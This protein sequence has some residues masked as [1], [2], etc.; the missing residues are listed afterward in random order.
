MK[1]NKCSRDWSVRKQRFGVIIF[2]TFAAFVLPR[3]SM[4]V[5]PQGQT[6]LIKGV[7]T[8]TRGLPLPGVTVRMEGTN[9]GVASDKDGKFALRVNGREGHIVVSFVGYKPQKLHFSGDRHFTI[10][11]VES[12][13][14]LDEV[15]V[16]AYGEQSKREV[17]GSV[18]SVKAGELRDNSLSNIASMLQGQLA[19]VVIQTTSGQP[20]AEAKVTVRGNASLAIET[21]RLGSD[22]LWVVDGVPLY[23][24]QEYYSGISPLSLIPTSDIER[25]DVLKDA[26]SCALYGSRAANGVV[27]VTTKSG[28]YNEKFTVSVNVTQS[29]SFRSLL[30]EMTVGNAERNFRLEAFRNHQEALYDYETNSWR[31]V[32]SPEEAEAT[33]LQYD[34]F[35]NRGTGATVNYLQD[36]L[37]RF[38]NNRNCWYRKVFQTNKVTD[39]N[40]SFSGGSG[41][42]AYNFGFGYYTEAGALVH[43]GFNRANLSGNFM[44]KPHPKVDGRLSFAF[45]R[46][47]IDRVNKDVDPYNGN[48]STTNV[49]EIPGFVLETSSLIIP[50]GSEAEKI[51]LGSYDKMREDNDSYRF[52]SAFNASYEVVDGLQL[53]TNFAFDYLGMHRNSFSPS[54]L[55][56]YGQSYSNGSEIRNLSGLNEDIIS[57]DRRFKDKHH[58]KVLAGISFQLDQFNSISGYGRGGSDKIYYV[59]RKGSPIDELTKRQMKEYNS[60]KTKS[61]LV[62]VFA[63]VGYNYMDKYMLEATFRR[64]GSSRFGKNT[65]WGSFPSVAL[66]YAFTEEKFMQGLKHILSYGKIRL[67]YGRT[68][69][70]F[71]SPY[72]AQGTYGPGVVTFQGKPTMMTVNLPNPDLT[73]EETDQYDAG[74]D[75]NLFKYRLGVV[76]DYYYRHTHNLL[77]PLTLP[78]DFTG[79]GDYMDNYCG[80]KNQGIELAVKADIIRTEKFRWNL[81]VNVARNWNR[82][83]K[84]QYDRSVGSIVSFVSV[85]VLGKE[86]NRLYVYDDRGFYKEQEEV[87]Y[88]YNNGQKTY[89]GAYNQYYRVGDRMI[90]DVNKDGVI[91]EKDRI[92]AGSALPKAAGGIISSVQWK[93]FDLNVVLPYS[94]GR[95]IL[96]NNSS[97]ATIDGVQAPIVG[98]L[99]DYVFYKE[100]VGNANMPPNRM[101]NGLNN[102]S[103]YLSSN[104][105][106]NSTLTIKQV[107]VGYTLPKR[108]LKKVG[109]RFFVTGEN[110]Y[111]F[112]T[113]YPG[114]DPLNANYLTGEDNNRAYPNSRKIT[115]GLNLKL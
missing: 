36:S 20:G 78:G 4:A 13:E 48:G 67:S 30:P 101:A 86:M 93:G 100:G 82:L 65:R 113:A 76:V 27:L 102:Y 41:T 89:L 26:A 40:V 19:G 38:Y 11:M 105:Y 37:N 29:F 54:S 72:L 85:S 115:F 77:Y 109:V 88:F 83:V 50:P 66:G 46:V 23:M 49:A 68:G 104:V 7:V 75:L 57:Y 59:T 25:V 84:S 74:I 47:G 97:L 90:A 28:R 55:D 99:N 87:P 21:A 33:G 32:S 24:N 80:I 22:P 111:T 81:S 2:L 8:D 107:S 6:C 114:V 64:D 10:K 92:D 53:K 34:Y 56:E 35:W 14:A 12:I 62:G 58:V 103:P 44:F 73:W 39:A 15:Q 61:G 69:R 42:M 79:F 63:R 3:L 71:E 5:V 94:I 1:K 112:S 51:L 31:Y 16:V 106:K 60:D 108:W 91:D 17:V 110:L 52:R 96:Y 70:Q 9:V 45:T 43:T 98:N 18:A 95:H